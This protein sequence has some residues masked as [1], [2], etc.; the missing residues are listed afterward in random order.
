MKLAH[1]GSEDYNI[2]YGDRNDYLMKDIKYKMRE[3]GVEV[4]ASKGEAGTSQ[5]E[6]NMKYSDALTQA[7]N[8]V[9]YKNVVKNIADK[10][11]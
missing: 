4:E 2:L 5:H 6:I 11:N 8:H 9:I 7:D 1:M 3:L 10:H